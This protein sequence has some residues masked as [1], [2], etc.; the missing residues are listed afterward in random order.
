MLSTISGAKFR[1][2][3][4]GFAVY[5]TVLEGDLLTGRSVEK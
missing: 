2:L 3:S 5:L 4:Q 1:P